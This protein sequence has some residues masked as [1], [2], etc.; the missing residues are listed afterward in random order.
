MG[1]MLVEKP[2]F[3]KV[4]ER[5]LL[6]ELPAFFQSFRECLTELVQNAHRAGATQIKIVL[7]RDDRT[8]VVEDN[9]SGSDNPKAFF[10]AGRTGWDESVVVDPAGLGFFSLLGLAEQVIVQSRAEGHCGWQA[11]LTQEAF[12]GAE[13]QW[14]P[15]SEQFGPLPHGTRIEAKLGLKADLNVIQRYEPAYCQF[16][17]LFPL[18]VNLTIIENGTA[19]TPTTARLSLEGRTFLDT[20]AGRLVVCPE[21]DPH[22]YSSGRCR[23]VWEHR[24]LKSSI[25]GYIEHAMKAYPDGQYAL[26]ALQQSRM[27]WIV[28]PTCGVRP[29]LP[30]RRELIADES[31]H[32]AGR[33]IAAS[34]YA[35]FN[36]ERI[37]EIVAGLGTAD[38]L[39]V[40]PA[41]T[42][43]IL[44]PALAGVVSPLFRLTHTNILKLCG[45]EDCPYK[46]YSEG[47]IEGYEDDGY[48][49]SIPESSYLIRNPLKVG[50][51]N[52]AAALNAS[53]CW[54]VASATWQ[55][56]EVQVFGAKIASIDGFD[57]GTCE[58]IAVLVDGKV[59]QELD[60]LACEWHTNGLVDVDG[61]CN[62]SQGQFLLRT[63]NPT[64][65]LKEVTDIGYHG[66]KEMTY[67]IYQCLHD[68]GMLD[69]YIIDQNDGEIDNNRIE[70]DITA[71]WMTVF[72]PEKV[73]VQERYNELVEIDRRLTKETGG[74]YRVL[75]M[76]DE[77]VK[78]NPEVD[79]AAET[80]EKLRACVHA[81]LDP[82]KW[83]PS[84]LEYQAKLDA[85]EARTSSK[86][87]EWTER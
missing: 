60:R 73:G 79:Q 81:S 7:N 80:A 45:W 29:K 21:D 86:E 48:H 62:L 15:I 10:T 6:R 5:R 68:G 63:S 70:N 85:E 50:N 31:L 47:H 58:R 13:I 34:L 78:R 56:I 87:N 54:A 65:L 75:S 67:F 32:A 9:G 71:A 52:L 77:F 37:K 26:A 51:S 12:Q 28:D 46:D 40:A 55:E 44:L 39:S 14:D 83:E 69:D 59:H 61:R 25:W 23:V 24:V 20:P 18:D 17:Y 57:F 74:L 76:L 49:P 16:W 8:L 72:Q 38:D 2:V 30:D 84:H 42:H 64:D 82:Y 22:L 3:L 27:F 53:G 41:R 33:M 4:D 19:T 11:M 1:T 35:A 66:A 43:Q 36:P